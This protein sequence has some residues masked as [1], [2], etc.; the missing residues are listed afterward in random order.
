MA[1]AVRRPERDEGSVRPV[2]RGAALDVHA[3]EKAAS[4]AHG[5]FYNPPEY[6]KT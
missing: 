4:E 3:Y 6:I 1:D 5:A 2:Q